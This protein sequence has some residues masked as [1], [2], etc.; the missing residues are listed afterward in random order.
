MLVL[1]VVTWFMGVDPSAYGLSAFDVRRIIMVVGLSLFILQLLI[2]QEARLYMIDALERIPRA[3]QIYL[4]LFI[5]ICL[6]SSLFSVAPLQS[7]MIT[8]QYITMM[9]VAFMFSG[10]IA[11]SAKLYRSVL[12]ILLIVSV[13]F[14]LASLLVYLYIQLNNYKLTYQNLIETVVYSGFTNVRFFNQYITWILPFLS[15][16]LL[17]VN[18]KWIKCLVFILL[19]YW[20]FL[21]LG[22]SSRAFVVE[23]V[24]VAVVTIFFFRKHAF[25]FLAY[26]IAAAILGAVLMY[27][28]LI[29]EASQSVASATVI[30]RSFV[31]DSTRLKVW[32]GV[33]DVF[34]KHPFFGV[35]P[36]LFP[37]YG[38]K[39]T[40]TYTI[41]TAAPHN[42]PLRMFAETGLVGTVLLAVPLL[43]GGYTLLRKTY[44]SLKSGVANQL[45][46]V[47]IASLISASFHALVSG[48]MTMP[49]SQY[50][51]VFVI[52]IAL[53]QFS[54][55]IAIAKI[56]Y[57]ARWLL[58]GSALL[59]GLVFCVISIYSLPALSEIEKDYAKNC[60]YVPSP[61][62][63]GIGNFSID[64]PEVYFCATNWEEV[65]IAVE[66]GPYVIN[67]DIK[68][69]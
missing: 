62:Y 16:P 6:Y 4:L 5:L 25:K 64:Y 58:I 68:E 15:L 8:C 21:G 3:I 41:M 9:A 53:K 22:T 40:D 33:F 43:V 69:E 23:W 17:Y 12:I 50:V 7:M 67:V 34:L 28:L 36:G 24:L 20:W 59:A 63:W 19:T 48:V 18:K 35:G 47:V 30:D 11:K 29:P 37:I 56:S 1:P 10:M 57:A 44:A 66:K 55:S 52:A 14:V 46:L 54:S 45:D 38:I 51:F 2:F 31:Q 27:L 60:N 49:L 13:A 39:M 65:R 61:Y 32:L 42:F 26:N